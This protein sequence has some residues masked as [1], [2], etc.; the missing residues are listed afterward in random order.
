MLELWWHNGQKES[1]F[2]LSALLS[3]CS[4]SFMPV[5]MSSHML[6]QFHFHFPPYLRALLLFVGV[7]M[8]MRTFVWK[9]WKRIH[10]VRSKPKWRF[11]VVTV[12][13][14]SYFSMWRLNEI[15]CTSKR[16]SERGR[17]R[18]QKSN[19]RKSIEAES[20]HKYGFSLNKNSHIV[21]RNM[22][23]IAVPPPHTHTHTPSLPLSLSLSLCECV[24]VCFGFVISF[25]SH[26]QFFHH[27]QSYWRWRWCHHRRHFRCR[28][29]QINV[30]SL[31]WSI[32]PDGNS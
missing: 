28:W 8:Y 9:F 5:L 6:H 15:V 31:D 18:R 19:N 29:R 21:V 7:F 14:L 3:Y 26:T 2:I 4:I 30:C 24:H 22:D 27:I 1:K 32:P 20:E 10:S 17:N 11:D 13:M 16:A 25:H 12:G 23:T